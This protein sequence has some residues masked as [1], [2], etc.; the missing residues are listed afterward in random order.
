M[1]SRPQRLYVRKLDDRP[2]RRL[3]VDGL[4]WSVTE[5]ELRKLFSAFGK[6]YYAEVVRDWG[7]WSRGF[8]YVHFQSAEEA[9]RAVKALNGVDFKG[10]KLIVEIETV[11]FPGNEHK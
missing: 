3:R 9:Q 11:S 4:R 2:Q 5:R 1:N 10:R 6:I 8:G 7:R